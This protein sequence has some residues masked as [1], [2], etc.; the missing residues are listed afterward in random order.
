[1]PGP[2]LRNQHRGKYLLPDGSR[3]AF[4]IA[5]GAIFFATGISDYHLAFIGCK[6]Q[7]LAIG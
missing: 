1:M 6:L 7:T 2:I 5:L 3:P 4:T